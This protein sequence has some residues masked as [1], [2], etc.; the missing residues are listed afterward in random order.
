[1]KKV[2]FFNTKG[3]TGKTTL[4][5]NY[6]WYL[7][8]KRKKKVLFIDFDPQVNL[9]KA[10]PDIPSSALKKGFENFVV[11]Y[12]KKDRVNLADYVVKI[13]DQIDLLP[14]SNS[15]SQL[16]EHLTNYLLNR[17]ATDGKVY[18]ALHRNVIIKRVLE[19]HIRDGAYDF[20]LID[21]QP[22]YSLLSTTAILYAQNIIVV[23]RPDLFSYLDIN[24]LFKIM[25]NLEEKF[26]IRVNIVCTIINAFELRRKISKTVVDGFTKNYGDRIRILEQKIRYLSPYQLSITMERRPVFQSFPDSEATQ[27]ILKAFQEIDILIERSNEGTDAIS[28]S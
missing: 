11:H 10:F 12:L 9:V 16:D 21:S 17:A 15:I 28:Q 26:G 13:N 24:Y 22:N 8:D 18:Q 7:A 2:V 20:V 23:V 1:M 14:S 25:K 6:G 27:D 4:C 3:G 5:Y 19:E